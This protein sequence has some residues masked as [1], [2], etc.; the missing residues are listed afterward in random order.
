[1]NDRIAR[2]I[3]KGHSLWLVDDEIAPASYVLYLL[4]RR[5]T[6]KDAKRMMHNW[7][8][9]A[10]SPRIPIVGLTL[11][12]KVIGFRVATWVGERYARL[13]ELRRW[14]RRDGYSTSEIASLLA[15]ANREPVTR[16]KSLVQRLGYGIRP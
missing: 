1:M 9:T 13:P 2:T 5:H 6:S 15:I 14:L 8:P 12:D 7:S 4:T 11:R 16:C 3:I 10:C